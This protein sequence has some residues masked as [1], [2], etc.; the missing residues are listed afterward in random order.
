MLKRIE[1]IKVENYDF[2]IVGTGPAGISLA[3]QLKKNDNKKILIIEAGKFDLDDESQE[4]YKGTI[5]NN[6][7]LEAPD[8]SRIR[9]F[10]GTSMLWGGMCRELDEIDLKNVIKEAQAFNET[11][12]IEVLVRPGHRKNIGRPTT[13]PVQNKNALMNT[14][15]I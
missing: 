10:G 11:S 9:A 8:V 5:I 1:N 13:T 6:C 3:F 15:N 2:V 14:L 7:N 12:F 4:Y